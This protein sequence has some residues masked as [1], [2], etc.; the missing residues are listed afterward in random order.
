MI[1]TPGKTLAMIEREVIEQS[2]KYYGT[3]ERACAGIGISVR[4]IQNRLAQYRADD[5]AREARRKHENETA[6]ARLV[7]ARGQEEAGGR[8]ADDGDSGEAS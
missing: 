7:Q 6:R 1:W 5:E 2:L 4:T 8:G 3:Q